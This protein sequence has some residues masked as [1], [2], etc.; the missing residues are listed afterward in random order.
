MGLRGDLQEL[1]FQE[2]HFKL[3]QKAAFA[4][5]WSLLT[6][7]YE[8]TPGI[9]VE[10]GTTVVRISY[11]DNEVLGPAPE[12]AYPIYGYKTNKEASKLLSLEE[13]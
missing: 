6:N 7:E 9:I 2:K 1:I 8:N 4:K 3:G 12:N 10:L 5:G 11:E 13:S